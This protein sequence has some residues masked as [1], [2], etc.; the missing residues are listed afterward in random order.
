VLEAKGSA[1]GPLPPVV[2]ADLR[3]TVGVQGPNGA[4]DLTLAGRLRNQGAALT[5]HLRG[6][7]L[8]GTLEAAVDADGTRIRDLTATARSLD[9]APLAAGAAGRV[10]VD[11]KA[12]GP[13]DRLSG[14]AAVRASDVVWQGVAVGAATIDLTGTDGVGRARFDVPALSVTGDA[15]LDAQ[16]V[17]AHVVADQ[18]P[19][20]A[21]Q[22][23]LPEG[24]TIAG[25]V[26]AAGDVRA[27]WSAPAAAEA[28]ARVASLELESGGRAA[29]ARRP[30][31]VAWSGQRLHVA[32]LDVEGE[33][34]HLRADATVGLAPSR[35]S[36][37]ASRSRATSR[38]CPCRPPGASAAPSPRTRLWRARGWRRASKVPST[39]RTCW[40]RARAACRCSRCRPA[41]WTSRAT[42]CASPTSW[43]TSWAAPSRCRRT[44]RSRRSCPRR[45]A[46]LLP[47]SA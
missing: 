23:L 43:S 44:R 20:A 24:R 26:T 36:K 8:G 1:R 12:A 18:T 4:Q 7:G 33:G 15:T 47:R 34:L 45:L 19:L 37:G 14:T 29:A 28:T 5:A 9:V 42:A 32:G 38:A 27:A 6:Q 13:L 21:L 31:D 35:R 41:A 25:A 3:G 16:G 10:D 46:P 2:D 22:P 39:R 30:F 17:R 11:V 40:S